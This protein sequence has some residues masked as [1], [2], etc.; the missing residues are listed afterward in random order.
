M[1][2]SIRVLY[3]KNKYIIIKRNEYLRTLQIIKDLE[4]KLEVER[5]KGVEGKMA[6]L[7]LD[8][9]YEWKREMNFQELED[10]E[11]N[12]KMK[13]KEESGNEDEWGSRE[14]EDI[15]EPRIEEKVNVR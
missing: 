15:E 7:K 13:V 4:Q 3:Q 14:E 6:G 9:V 5:T 2:E 11:R 12:V 8:E 10:L 1:E